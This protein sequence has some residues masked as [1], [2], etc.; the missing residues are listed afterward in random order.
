MR[1][2][3]GDYLW[4]EC[5][6]DDNLLQGLL[7]QFLSSNVFKTNRG[8]TEKEIH[9]SLRW[10]YSTVLLLIPH[11]SLMGCSADSAKWTFSSHLSTI[12]LR[13]KFA[14]LLSTFFKFFMSL[15]GGCR[16][17]AGL[18]F[19]AFAT[20]GVT[21]NKYTHIINYIRNIKIRYAYSMHKLLGGTV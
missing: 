2:M 6:Q 4:S 18:P 15:R 21:F 17:A 13:I 20:L 9:R 12:S 11:T 16:D 5:W 10:Y 8:S 7:S 1:S 14:S 3:S 19:G